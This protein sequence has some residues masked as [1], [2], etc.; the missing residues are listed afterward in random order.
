MPFG[1]QFDFHDGIY[2]IQ[3]CNL[4]NRQ[5]NMV[6]TMN[7]QNVHKNRCFSLKKSYG[8]GNSNTL[9]KMAESL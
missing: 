4:D 1:H 9:F 6:F 5:C 7:V 3:P 2:H 8:T